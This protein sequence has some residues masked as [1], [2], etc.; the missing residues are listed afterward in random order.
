MTH[1]HNRIAPDWIERLAHN[2]VF[3]FGSNLQGQHAGGA[4]RIAHSHFGAEWGVGVGPT[5]QCYA[6]PT[7]HGDLEAIRPYVKQFVNYAIANPSKHFLLTRIGCG[8]AG[9][10]DAD[11]CRLFRG[12]IGYPN[13]LAVPNIAV[14]RQWLPCL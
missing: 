4:A 10:S 7:M 8:I 11:M 9:F 1:R 14:P 3:V 13:V 5:G 6:I 12:G 2:E